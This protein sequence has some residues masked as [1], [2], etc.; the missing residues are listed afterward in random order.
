MKVWLCLFSTALNQSITG[1]LFFHWLN[2]CKLVFLWFIRSSNTLVILPISDL[3]GL[4]N[5]QAGLFVKFGLW[6]LSVMNASSLAM[7][8]TLS[9][10]SFSL[11]WFCFLRVYIYL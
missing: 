9:L 8:S 5:R 6:S 4:I 7:E 2:L 10:M 11:R 3:V 1:V